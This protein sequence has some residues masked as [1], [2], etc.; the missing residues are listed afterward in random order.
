MNQ[1][2]SIDMY[3]LK[4]VPLRGSLEIS[5]ATAER[6]KTISVGG[7]TTSFAA[8]R[9]RTWTVP[10]TLQSGKNT[11]PFS[12][13]SVDPLFVLDIRWNPAQP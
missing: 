4:E 7:A 13:P 6:P 11:I 3:N 9:I 12:S 2:A 1:A 5:A 8:G 10:L